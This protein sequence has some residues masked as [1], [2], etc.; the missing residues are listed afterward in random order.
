MLFFCSMGKFSWWSKIG[1]ILIFPLWIIFPQS[2]FFDSVFTGIEIHSR[3]GR[4]IDIL[5]IILLTAWY[6]VFR[7]ITGRSGLHEMTTNKKK[8][9]DGD[10]IVFSLYISTI[11][12]ALWSLFM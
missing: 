2:S 7:K 5:A 1:L 8:I 9:L 11:L 6:V 4:E 3:R 10:A 12:T